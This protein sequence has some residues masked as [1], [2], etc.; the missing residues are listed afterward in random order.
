MNKLIID[1][2]EFYFNIDTSDTTMIKSYNKNYEVVY[3][4][5]ILENIIRTNYNTGDLLIIDSN[6][7][8]LYLQHTLN[9][10]IKY[11]IF[12]ATEENKTIESVLSIIDAMNNF[13]KKNKLIV[14]GG[15]ITQDV[16]G[17]VAGIYK[18]GIQWV[19]IPTTLLAMTDS[20][21]GGKVGVNRTS[22]NI[23]GMFS[24]PNK[25]IVS[26]T[27]MNT[28][29]KDMIVSGLGE[30]LKLS[31]IGGIDTYNYFKTQLQDNNY[32]N[33]IKMA[34][35]VKKVIIEQDELEVYER[36]ILNYG[37]TI[38]HAIESTTNYEIPHGIAV[39]IGMYLINKCFDHNLRNDINETIYNLIDQK[40][41][42]IKVNASKVIEHI[43]NDKKNNGDM[44]CFIILKELGHSIISYYPMNDVRDKIILEINNL[45]THVNPPLHL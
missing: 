23:L 26:S 5:Y 42:K 8:S 14:I 17:F 22:K 11:Y 38:G 4:S 37:H 32:I 39:L 41:L 43:L 33:I 13:T 12:T 1:E 36:K 3:N 44:I 2:K 29:A 9:A 34:T 21:I 27:F 19:L 15:G 35:S 40:F 20:C 31:L 10:D 28:L 30:A 25:V 18:R 24:A 7:Y 16:G 45:F 6:V